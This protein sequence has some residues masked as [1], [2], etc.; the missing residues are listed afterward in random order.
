MVEA[1]ERKRV[2]SMH[3]VAATASFLLLILRPER[4]DLLRL[5]GTGSVQASLQECTT[6]ANEFL[7]FDRHS[8]RLLNRIPTQQRFH[9]NHIIGAKE[10]GEQLL[11]DLIEVAELR[12]RMNLP[13]S[14]R[15]RMEMSGVPVRYQVN[16]ASE[17]VERITLWPNVECEMPYG[18]GPGEPPAPV[19]ARASSS[20]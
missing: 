8:G 15:E 5:V 14:G 13:A 1:V 20:C 16:R 6:A 17:A 19:V 11:I 7:V 4:H 2:V 3:N 9:F 18:G 12:N 10:C